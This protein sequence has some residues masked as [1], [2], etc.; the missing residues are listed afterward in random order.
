[1]KIL[2]PYVF[3]I[4]FFLSSFAQAKIETVHS[5]QLNSPRELK[6][7]LPRNYDPKAERVY[8]L[9]VVLDG[10]YLFEPVA[11]NVDYQTYWEDIPECFVVGVNQEIYKKTDF[12][13]DEEG[14]LTEN[15]ENFY[16]FLAKELI[17]YLEQKYKVSAFKVIVG[18]D[19]GANFINHFLLKNKDLFRAYI[20][21]SPDLEEETTDKIKPQLASL[22]EETFYYLAT[23]SEDFK[24]IKAEVLESN[25]K[26]KTVDN[27]KLKYTFH[28]FVDAN[29]YSLVGMG[30]PKALNVIFTRYKPIDGK[31]Y[32]EKILTYD[33]SPYDYLIKKYDDI[34]YFYGFKKQLTENDIRAIAA[35]SKKKDDLTSLENLALL[36]KEEYPKSMLSA[37][38]M[39]MYYEKEGSLSKGTITI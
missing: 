28:N 18:H 30:I 2:L 37:Y 36:V 1:M 13:H 39:G 4:G 8:P 19:E 15:G 5:D 11:G 24:S 14:N 3:V 21:L 20:S 12:E 27:K 34:K 6:I 25:E 38:Y 9:I 23:G 35:A 29:H 10:D 31:E 16:A 22:N 26:L 7:Q 17:P 32:R 33:G